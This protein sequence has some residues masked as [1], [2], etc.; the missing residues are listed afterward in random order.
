MDFIF[1]LMMFPI[2]FYLYLVESRKKR[3][4]AAYDFRPQNAHGGSRFAT[5]D[6]LKKAGLF[7]RKGVPI[8]FS[9]N[10][11]RALRYPG[12]GHLLTV[13]AARTGK[14]ATLLANALL[15]LRRSCICIDPKGENA[16]ITGHKR[17]RFG[18]VFV[19]NPFGILLDAM[20]GLLQARFNPMDIL[21][22]LSNA[23]HALCDKLAAALVWDEGKEGIHFTTA[24]RILVSGVI[25]ALKRYGLRPEQNLAT[26]AR[27]INGDVADFCRRTVKATKDPFIIQKLGRFAAADPDN[28]EMND[29]ISTARTQLGFIGN[30]AVAESLS[31]SD[32]RFSDLKRTR[33]TVYIVL[34]LNMLDVCDKYFRLILETALSDLLNEG[35]KGNRNPVLAIIDEMAQL[36]PHMKSLENAMGMAAGAA[37]LQL[38]CVLQD[39]S[40]LKGMFP[41]TWETFIQNCGVTT[42]FGAR[43]QTTREYVSRL[44]G[45]TEVLSRSRSVSI[46][47]HGEPHVSDS[48]NQIGRPLLL[49]HEVGQLK[50][51]E[52]IAF[53]EGVRCG[54]VKAKRKFYW[55]VFWGGYRRNP[56]VRNGGGLFRWLVG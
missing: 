6:D 46:D 23:F 54:P 28:R 3:V 35:Q 20:E 37:G 40:Q 19:L 10:G 55:K 30:A 48:V 17:L 39:L 11:R 18:K 44:S 29:V 13:A 21:D 1:L 33:C 8:G 5:N 7:R 51:D 34:P 47:R 22:P 31:G 53:V 27:I 26:V 2:F 45:T 16:A 32:F 36:G 24:A 52:M 43:D 56:Y 12:F 15:A 14:G 4:R 41:Q 9:P 38:W 42:W 50:P 49:P 25:A